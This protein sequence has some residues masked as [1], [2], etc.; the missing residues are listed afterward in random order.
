MMVKSGFLW[1][2]HCYNRVISRLNS[3]IGGGRQLFSGEFE[4]SIDDKGRLIIPAKFRD[5]LADGVFVTRG[6]DG[7]LFAY[8][9]AEWKTLAKKLVQL[10]L[11]QRNARYFNRMMFSGADCKLDKQGR[12]LLPAPLREH[13]AI[14]SDV[15]VIGLNSRLEIWSKE[16]WREVT[17]QIEEESATF[18]EKLSE[19]GI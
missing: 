12:I 1:G 8:P 13:A 15:V 4:H 9:I 17:A 19:L 18:A 3:G 16:R 5:E 10:P 14:D 6:L 2:I 7:C 11:A